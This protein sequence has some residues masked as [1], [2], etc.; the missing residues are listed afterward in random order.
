MQMTA[1]ET[2]LS[3]APDDPLL[4]FNKANLLFGLARFEE[5]QAELL[6]VTRLRPGDIL[7][8][9]VPLAAITW[10]ADTTQARQHLQAALAAPGERL[11]PFTRAFYRAIA[12]TGLG[13]A[14]PKR[15]SASWKPRRPP[16]PGRRPRSTTPTR[17]YS[18][19][20]ATRHCPAWNCFYN[21]S[22]RSRLAPSHKSRPAS[23]RN[24]PVGHH[25]REAFPPARPAG[26]PLETST[27]MIAQNGDMNAVSKVDVA[28]ISS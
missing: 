5:S 4:H 8:A 25:R 18:T 3:L 28:F 13:R 22:S 16:G 20:S 11:T 7:G 1:Y 12:L 27:S 26:T 23:K 24:Q 2:A 21:S 14:G 6:T 15:R 10:P 17:H 19:G 9:A